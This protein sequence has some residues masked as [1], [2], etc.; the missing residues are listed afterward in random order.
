MDLSEGPVTLE[1]LVRHR[2]RRVD[3][4]AGPQRRSAT[5]EH[6]RA[7]VDG[8]TLPRLRTDLVRRSALVL[9]APVPRA[10]RRDHRGPPPRACPRSSE[11]SRNWDY[12]YCWMRDASMAAATLVRLGSVDEAMDLLG[13]LLRLIDGGGRCT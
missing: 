11:G 5:I 4:S 10:Y 8:L 9:K 6:W 13:W 2:C 12:R 3:A 7:W 1:L